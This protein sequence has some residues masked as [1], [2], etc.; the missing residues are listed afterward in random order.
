MEI[1]P[2]YNDKN[3]IADDRNNG[4]FKMADDENVFKIIADDK[5][6]GSYTMA[7]D[8]NMALIK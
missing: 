6:N 3:I 7:D 2:L 4:Y 1:W 8:E 5:N